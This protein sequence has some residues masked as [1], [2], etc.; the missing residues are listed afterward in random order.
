MELK[1]KQIG[2]NR[3]SIILKPQF[4]EFNNCDLP[5]SNCFY[6]II[7][8]S[9]PFSLTSISLTEAFSN[10]NL[11]LKKLY[12]K[13]LIDNKADCYYVNKTLFSDEELKK[14]KNENEDRLILKSFSHSDQLSLVI[15]KDY[16]KLNSTNDNDDGRIEMTFIDE[17]NF[18]L[19]FTQAIDNYI[20]IENTKSE[21]VSYS[22]FVYKESES[23]SVQKYNY[24]TNGNLFLLNFK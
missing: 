15:L 16:S 6:R 18:R 21:Q 1:S 22:L 19:N 8:S 17:I 20:C 3:N 12:Y 9:R 23:E 4:M 7:I 14:N 5:N 13:S 10:T 2:I 11:Q 24:L